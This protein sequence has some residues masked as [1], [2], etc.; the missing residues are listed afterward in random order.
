MSTLEKLKLLNQILRSDQ[1]VTDIVKYTMVYDSLLLK[2]SLEERREVLDHLIDYVPTRLTK[3]E[4]ANLYEQIMM[5]ENKYDETI[6]ALRKAG[7]SIAE[8][9]QYLRVSAGTVRNAC[10]R[11]CIVK[12]RTPE[13]LS[14]ESLQEYLNKKYTI[15][16]IATAANCHRSTVLKKKAQLKNLQKS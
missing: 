14:I 9:A 1:A 5:K 13:K 15:D 10:K 16:Q 7:M 12:D 2:A 4:I 6:K 11:L 8:I 3:V